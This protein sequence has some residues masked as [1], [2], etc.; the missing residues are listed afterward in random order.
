[1][2]NPRVLINDI[3]IY[4]LGYVSDIIDVNEKKTFQKDQ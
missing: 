1:M 4:A 2:A 3:D